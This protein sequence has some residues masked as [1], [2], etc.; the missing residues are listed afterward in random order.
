M[1]HNKNAWFVRLGDEAHNRRFFLTF[2]HGSSF[3]KGGK[4]G[5]GVLPVDGRKTLTDLGVTVPKSK[6]AM[7]RLE[8]PVFEAVLKAACGISFNALPVLGGG[9]ADEQAYVRELLQPAVIDDLLGPADG[10]VEEIVGMSVR[11]RY[12]VGKL[13]Q[14]PRTANYSYRKVQYDS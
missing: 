9:S 8:W 14:F 6:E 5:D 2:D 4:E 1:D 3:F 7:V 12:L 10:P 13:L 11:Y